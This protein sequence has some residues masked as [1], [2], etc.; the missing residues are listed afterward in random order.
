[1]SDRCEVDR[2]RVRLNARSG[3]IAGI[4]ACAAAHTCPGVLVDLELHGRTTCAWC[5]EP[6]EAVEEGDVQMSVLARRR[7]GAQPGDEVLVGPLGAREQFRVLPGSLVPTPPGAVLVP[8][9]VADRSG[10]HRGDGDVMA[11]L[12][13]PSGVVWPVDVIAKEDCE[14]VGMDFYTRYLLEGI[15]T[16]SMVDVTTLRKRDQIELA[17]PATRGGRFAAVVRALRDMVEG[18]VRLFL[19]A[20]KLALRVAHGGL[21]DEYQDVCRAGAGQLEMLGIGAGDQVRVSW[22]HLSVTAALYEHRPWDDLSLAQSARSTVR[23]GE[24]SQVGMEYRISM[25]QPLRA[26]LGMPPEAVVIVRRDALGTI[27]RHALRFAVP[28]AGLMVGI[29]QARVTWPATLAIV[30]VL[31]IVAFVPLRRAG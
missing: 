3:L 18:V 24:G 5:V 19:G 10:E 2:H 7:I 1:M 20:P 31:M 28:A 25:P 27:R 21:G 15:A 14:G 29:A 13:G 8:P 11:A 17:T 23:S 26:A 16:G 12:R 4:P 6:T 22:G 9:S 30:F